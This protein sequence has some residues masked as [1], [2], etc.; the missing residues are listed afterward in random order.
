M[1]RG[2]DCQLR[3][4]RRARRRL[5]GRLIDSPT[6]FEWILLLS[7]WDQG[8]DQ[9]RVLRVARKRGFNTD[10]ADEGHRLHRARN[11]RAKRPNLPPDNTSDQA[12]TQQAFPS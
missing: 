12:K 1:R 5:S 6:G 10:L 4:P 7:R 8:N 3:R 9:E 11:N 2:V